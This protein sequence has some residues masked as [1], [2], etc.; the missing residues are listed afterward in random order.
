MDAAK[1]Y[2]SDCKQACGLIDESASYLIYGNAEAGW[3]KIS[4]WSTS[5]GQSSI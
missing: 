3:V 1:L 2:T 5:P 4:M